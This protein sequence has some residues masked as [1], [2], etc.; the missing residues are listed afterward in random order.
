[1]NPL[2]Q[3]EKPTLTIAIC[4]YGFRPSL[5]R[6]LESIIETSDLIDETIISVD[7][8]SSYSSIADV[9]R[10]FESRLP[11]PRVFK[12]PNQGLAANRNA[13]IDAATS[14]YLL[15]LDDDARLSRTFLSTARECMNP[16]VIV[17]GYE[18]RDGDKVEPHEPDFLGFLQ[19]PARVDALSALVMNSTIFPRRF[20]K[21]VY[22]DEFYRF[23][24][25]E[26]EIALAAV[27]AGLSIVRVDAGNFHDRSDIRPEGQASHVLRSRGH[28]GIRRHLT[29][30]RRPFL[31]L[32][33]L[34]YGLANAA[35]GGLQRGGVARSFRDALAFGIGAAAAL[36]GRRRRPESGRGR[37]ESEG[38]PRRGRVKSC[39]A[40]GDVSY[41]LQVRLH[42]LGAA[43][44][45]GSG[46][47][48]ALRAFAWAGFVSILV[49]RN[50]LTH[51]RRLRALAR[52]WAWQL[53]RRIGKRGVAA[54]WPCGVRLVL[55]RESNLAGVII[56]CGSHEPIEHLFMLRFAR[57]GDVVFD[58]GANI[59]LYTVFLASKGA[60]VYAFEPS[61]W[62]RANLSR[63]VTM[64]RLEHR[65]HIFPYAVSASDG[66]ALLTTNLES[67]NVLVHEE[68]GQTSERVELR[69]L[70][71]LFNDPASLPAAVALMK[72][73]VEDHDEAALRGAEKL[74]I[75]DRPVIVVEVWD[76][77][78]PTRAFLKSMG[79][80]VYSYDLGRNRLETIPSA[81][82]G[83]A[84][85]IAVPDGQRQRVEAR[86]MERTPT[87]I[88][89]PNVRWRM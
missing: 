23:G 80:E 40:N 22:F 88:G 83:Q 30:D 82:S 16:T 49:W 81:F 34:F 71:S 39:L 15:F 76:G 31:A 36:R 46:L 41:M 47:I 3:S 33:F 50:P 59:G 57:G 58:V 66:E 7:D 77:G 85:F 86:L 14:S 56:A 20:L 8:P 43:R 28:F 11:S 74:L 9:A 13:C 70:D 12:G 45:R 79:Y 10:G 1:L 32:G 51:R 35:Y 48:R 62:A 27:R 18:W 67:S 42:G 89:I 75:R 61:T 68:A 25:E 55:P 64:N 6:S 21:A 84:N 29:Y 44:S 17:T 37:R 63:N 69:A 19:R 87:E 4:T 24:S 54:S 53:A 73:D 78:K 52:L 26:A 2:A 65:V 60:T 5:I 72:V 38:R